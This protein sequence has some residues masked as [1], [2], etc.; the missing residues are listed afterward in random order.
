MTRNDDDHLKGEDGLLPGEYSNPIGNTLRREPRLGGFYEDE[1]EYEEPDRDTDYSSGYRIDSVAEE[2]EDSFPDEEDKDIFPANDDDPGYQPSSIEAWHLGSSSL[3]ES[4]QSVAER[5]DA[6]LEREGYLEGEDTQ[7]NEEN[8]EQESSQKWPWGLIATAIVAF[9][10]L[11]AGGY[12]VMQQRAATEAEL[13]QLRATLATSAS[14]EDVG[15]NR[16]ALQDLKKSYDELAATAA[17]LTLENRRLTDTVTGLEAQLGVQQAVLTKTTPAANPVNP[18]AA[19]AVASL[20][21]KAPLPSANQVKPAAVLEVSAPQQVAPAPVTPKPVAPKP[22]T[23]KSVAPKSV[24]PTRPA[25]AP[26]VAA[27]SSGPWFVNF[28]SYSSRN[29]AETW[30]SKLHPGTGKVIIA[31][32][33]KD[34]QTLYRVRVVGLASRSSA[35]EVA[36]QLETEMR[37]SSLWVGKE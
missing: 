27:A 12:G 23:P 18:Q 17:E 31:P 1:D 29:M 26:T 20:Y 34:G 9:I 11:T 5:P 21:G 22:V 13:R 33:P 24:A 10:L 4:D 16:G 37:V 36:R 19:E 7:I 15:A 30:A 14:H 2:F 35:Q 3:S 28:S 8:D 6:W 32:T 25:T